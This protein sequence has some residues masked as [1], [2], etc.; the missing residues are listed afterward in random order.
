MEPIVNVCRNN[1]KGAVKICDT[2]EDRVCQGDI[3]KNVKYIENI[4]EVDDYLEVSMINFPK[5]IIL[6]Q[7]CDLSED[8]DFRYNKTKVHADHDKIL[9]SFLV[10]PLYTEEQ[11]LAGEHLSLIELERENTNEPMK[12]HDFRKEK[13]KKTLMHNNEIPRYHYL[14]FPE[15]LTTI[16]NS[17]IDF[18]HYFSININYLEELKRNNFICRIAMPYREFISQRFSNYLSRIGLP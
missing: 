16:S 9:I 6:S 15:S 3:I 10:A 4:G 7:D 8:Y 11:V 18:K 13:T 12:M 1:E 5:V 17:F 2:K 14:K